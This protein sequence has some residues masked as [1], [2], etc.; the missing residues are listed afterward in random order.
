[1][2]K[3]GSDTRRLESLWGGAFGDAYVERNRRAGERRGPF[4]KGILRG[5]RV[6]NCLEIGCNVGANLQ[7]LA[8][9]VP[10]ESVYGLDVNSAALA[11]LRRALP[12]LNVV[13]GPARSVPFR[14][15]LFDLV[16]TM[17]VL[18]HMA[19]ESLPLVLGEIHRCSRRYILCGEY[20]SPEPV[21]VPYRGQ[22]G[23]LFKR[24]F[25][26]LYMELFPDL[27]LKRKGFLS[28]RTGWDDV[29]Y[30]LFEKPA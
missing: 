1:M 18:I 9:A 20:F 8:R 11:E 15:G 26:A 25:G 27:K 22:T 23:A 14:D 19:P 28:K 21:A 2:T 17:G 4:W 7:W 10:P 12:R 29:T 13:C 16:F 3:T 5:L 30:W 6:R 24:D